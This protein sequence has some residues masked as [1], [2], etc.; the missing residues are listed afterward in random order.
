MYNNNLGMKK[1]KNRG[2]KFKTLTKN[3]TCYL[4]IRIEI[5][6]YY[7][8]ALPVFFTV[9]SCTSHAIP[10]PCF[11]VSAFYLI[12]HTCG[13]NTR[14][15]NCCQKENSA[16]PSVRISLHICKYINLNV[17]IPSSIY[18]YIRHM[19]LCMQHFCI[20]SVGIESHHNVSSTPFPFLD[21]TTRCFILHICKVF[22]VISLSFY[23][24]S[25]YVYSFLLLYLF[26]ASSDKYHHGEYAVTTDE[27]PI[28][29]YTQQS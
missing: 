20:E 10:L 5:P 6:R 12:S 15:G 11:P 7:L 3:K 23:E 22:T 28:K 21:N 27:E 24:G 8:S 18:P 14:Q 25:L 17:S 2:V 9:R 4:F 13:T 1:I 29:T 16:K 26:T 19:P